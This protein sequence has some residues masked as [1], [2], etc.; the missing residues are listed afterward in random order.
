MHNSSEILICGDTHCRLAHVVATALRL[1]PM[2][3][4]LLGD[5]EALRPLHI[6][7]EPICDL[8]WFITGNHDTDRR[9]L[10]ANLVDSNL[11][12]RRLDGRVVTLPDGTRL[13][14]LGGVFR[15]GIWSPPMPAKQSNYEAWAGS[16]PIGWQDRGE[17]YE[18]QRLTHRS[19]IF[20][21][22]YLH[23]AAETADILVTH[24]AGSSHPHGF[25][26]I[27]ELA[28][29]MGVHTTF[30]GHHHD[31]LDYSAKWPSLGF[32]AFGVGLRGITGRA[33]EVIRSGEVD[34]RRNLARRL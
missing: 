1:K 3:V 34:D 27:D 21:D 14:G 7:L 8:V 18:T 9:E 16:L 20:H 12:H 17:I 10:W 19:T 15:Q 32:K 24:E 22:D 26:A 25:E 29:A 5:I 30:H 6:E 13:A 2:A 23:L 4:V 11:A 28:A 31:R 33:G